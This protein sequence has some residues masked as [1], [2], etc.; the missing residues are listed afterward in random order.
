[1]FLTCGVLLCLASDLPDHDDALGGGVRGEPLQ[2]IDEVSSVE[3]I[4]CEL[5]RN[6]QNK[7]ECVGYMLEC[8]GNILECDWN[9][10]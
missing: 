6:I 2:A 8:I 1:M 4:S 3:G 7:L 5:S 9:I 10:L